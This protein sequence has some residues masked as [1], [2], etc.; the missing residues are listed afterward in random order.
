M[1]RRTL[2][3]LLL[4]YA[5]GSLCAAGSA[6]PLTGVEFAKALRKP[7]SLSL[8][9][10]PLREMLEKIAANNHVAILLDRRVDPGQ[11][12]HFATNNQ[13][14]LIQFLVEVGKKFGLDV[15]VYED[16]I[17]LGPTAKAK[18]L[19]TALRRAKE[20]L[21]ATARGRTATK[22]PL[23]WKEL[24]Q[25]RAIFSSLAQ[26]AKLNVVQAEL[27]DHD[28]LPPQSLPPLSLF[29]RMAI[30]LFQFD[31]TPQID[32]QGTSIRPIP[33]PAD[34]RYVVTYSAKDAAKLAGTVKKELPG[35]LVAVQDGKVFVKALY[36][37][38]EQIKRRS[39]DEKLGASSIS[40]LTK[41]ISGGKTKKPASLEN[42]VIA[43]LKVREK[44]GNLLPYFEKNFGIK[45]VFD[46]KTLEKKNV[47]A[48][49]VVQL[50]V[51]GVG[52]DALLEKMFVPLG[53]KSVREGR[54][55]RLE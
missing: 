39:S 3:L 11:E 41:E 37:D 25:P 8:E 23:V 32:P 7:V 42:I 45:F 26:H 6:A 40:R 10:M 27:I 17:Y 51:E 29:D 2:T 21:S 38:Q 18:N 34:L 9:G 46:W 33:L 5:L 49:T 50:E 52:I 30:I 13:H 19:Q 36:E 1:L 48:D 47:T 15:V 24:A 43:N 28:L 44:L 12:V 53:L 16:L 55:V 31:L 22:K 35:A 14:S 20:A 54:T 4:L